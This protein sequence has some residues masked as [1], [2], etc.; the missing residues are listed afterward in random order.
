MAG[1]KAGN[2]NELISPFLR[3]KILEAEQQFGAH[4]FEYRALTS[5]YIVSPEE[6]RIYPWERRRHYEADMA[7]TF[8]DKPLVGVERL[9]RRTILIEPST[10][11]AAHC[12]WCLRGQYPTGAMQR[13]DIALA[14][15]YTDAQH[16]RS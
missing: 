14:A 12:R 6:N 1:A 11:C 13:D 7:L 3:K 15:R 5:Q 16:D 10:V 9:Y 2:F 4:S 8:E